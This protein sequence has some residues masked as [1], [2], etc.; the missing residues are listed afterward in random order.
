MDNV[1]VLKRRG[2]IQLPMFPGVTFTITPIGSIERDFATSAAARNLNLIAEGKA[3]AELYGVPQDIAFEDVKSSFRFGVTAFAIELA[4]VHVKA[5]T[6]IAGEDGTPCEPSR[7]AISILFNEW[8]PPEPGK[9][10]RTIAAVFVEKIDGL[11]I[12]EPAAKN[13]STVSPD[14]NTGEAVTGAQNAPQTESAPPAS[15]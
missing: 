14:T 9:P 10:N 12:L 11:S 5:W 15:P 3:K 2:L 6:G 13:V 8:A 4:A 1:F 7:E